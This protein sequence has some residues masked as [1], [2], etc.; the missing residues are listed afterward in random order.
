KRQGRAARAT[1]QRMPLDSSHP[2]PKVSVGIMTKNSGPVFR[3]VMEALHAQE[4]PWP[5]ELVVVDC[6]STDGTREYAA[7]CGALMH[8]YRV[9]K[10]R[11]GPAR[12]Y[13]LERCRGEALLVMSADVIPATPDWL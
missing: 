12:D 4:T 2:Q 8:E 3:R 10:W 7:S 1:W 6:G 11:Y 9:E 13:M 5:F